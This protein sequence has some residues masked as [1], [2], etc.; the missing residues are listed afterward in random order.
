MVSFIFFY[1]E[2]M[3]LDW[4][5]S[6]L[7]DEKYFDEN[8]ANIHLANALADIHSSSCAASVSVT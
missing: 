5:H 4:L 1:V 3:F 8:L 7:R 2:K 6:C